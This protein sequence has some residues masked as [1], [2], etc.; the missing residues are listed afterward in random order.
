MLYLPSFKIEADFLNNLNFVDIT[1]KVHIQL[2][3][4]EKKCFSSHFAQ[5]DNILN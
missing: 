2:L 5:T 4:R 1:L 3:F